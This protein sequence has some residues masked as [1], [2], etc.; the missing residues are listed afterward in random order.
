MFLYRKSIAYVLFGDDRPLTITEMNT[1][2]N[3]CR[4]ASAIDYRRRRLRRQCYDGDTGDDEE[5]ELAFVVKS[6]PSPGL[7]SCMR[8][9]D[10]P[11]QVT[12]VRLV[13]PDSKTPEVSPE[14]SSTASSKSRPSGQKKID[15]T[16]PANSEASTN[17]VKAASGPRRPVI[18]T[19]SSSSSPSRSPRVRSPVARP[20]SPLGASRKRQEPA[21]PRWVKARY[22]E[23]PEDGFED[24]SDHSGASTP[25]GMTGIGLGLQG[26]GTTVGLD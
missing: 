2:K 23:A 11:R 13:E 12:R 6:R 7:R 1:E 15:Q 25:V 5:E 26:Q 24:I 3:R 9:Q 16:G 17:S 21:Y 14:P 22:Q 8:A 10:S 4:P 20:S 18:V 19:R